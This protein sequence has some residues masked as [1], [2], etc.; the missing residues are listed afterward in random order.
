MTKKKRLRIYKLYLVD[1]FEWL[2]NRNEASIHAVVTDPPYG[3]VEYTPEQLSKRRNGNGG[4]WRLPQNYDGHKRSPM[5]RFTVLTP[6]D[7]LRIRE[8]H[9]RLA[10]LLY[11]VLVPGGHVV[12]SSQNL[13]SHLVIDEFV[14]AGFEMRGQVARIVKTLR[15]GDRPKGAH[16][17]YAN[18]SVSP[19]SC[20]EPWLIF[21]K[22]C[23]GLVR[24]NLRRWGTGALRRE[25]EH[26]PFSDL[27]QSSPARGQERRLSPHPSLKPQAFMRQIVH[28]VLP[29]RTG[30]ILDPFMGSGSTIAAAAACG[31]CSIGLEV[32]ALYFKLA[33]RAIPTLAQY[34]PHEVNGNGAG[35]KKG[36][37]IVGYH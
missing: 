12:V 7:H 8:F 6:T 17:K 22:P 37:E 27:I 25:S 4:I 9:S 36:Q 2:A 26:K 3:I 33:T 16:K 13:L 30:I 35:P 20:W 29:L 18:I 19:R 15:G 34:T 31:L 28:A 24:E 1:A 32:N 23:Q 14:S 11:K 5:P 21:R 10:P